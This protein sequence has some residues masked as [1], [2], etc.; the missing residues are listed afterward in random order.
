MST[1]LGRLMPSLVKAK[2]YAAGFADITEVSWDSR[3]I[4]VGVLP[5]GQDGTSTRQ[6]AIIA[7]LT[8]AL[9]SYTSYGSTVSDIVFVD[10][11]PERKTR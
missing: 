9:P 10:R 4:R 5:S 11:T 7:A 6:R 1:G 3:T 8:T 2:L